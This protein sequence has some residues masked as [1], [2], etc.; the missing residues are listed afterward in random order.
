MLK[1]FIERPKFYLS[2]V[3]IC[4]LLGALNVFVLNGQRAPANNKAPSLSE[5]AVDLLQQMVDLE[6]TDHR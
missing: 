6:R 2:I 4:A 3:A 1:D 5:R